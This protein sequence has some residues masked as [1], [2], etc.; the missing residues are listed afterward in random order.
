M[1]KTSNLLWGIVLIILGIIFGLN[2]LEITNI[3]IFF[4]GWWTLFIIIP[5]FIDLFKDE[6]KLGNIIG[7]II[8]IL[9]LLGCQDIINFKIILKLIIP[10]ILVITGL[11]F[12]FK[13]TINTKVKQEI[14]KIN[15]QNGKEYCATFGGQ[16]IDLTNEELKNCNLTAVFGG[17][18]CNLK[19]SIIKDNIVINISAIFGGVTIHAPENINV[20]VI[21]TPIFG[22]VSDERKIKPK[23]E[24]YT[25]YIN[26]T[27]MF[28]GVEIK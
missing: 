27:C 22:G 1:N 20:K 3:N 17:I 21:S 25:L 8:G 12:I 14:K 11:S 9:L 18:K 23:D 13:D 24:K 19:E 7:L 26:A 6:D 28:G 16:T 5:C 4:N 15:T 2:A 10:I